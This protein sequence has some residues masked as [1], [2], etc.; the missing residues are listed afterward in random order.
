MDPSV[1][2]ATALNISLASPE[3]GPNL[4]IEGSAAPAD[5]QGRSESAEVG[6]PRGFGPACGGR[7]ASCGV[8]PPRAATEGVPDFRRFRMRD[9]GA[10]PMYAC[11]GHSPVHKE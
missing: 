3:M 10:S 11:W 6:D 9:K 4:H 2:T 1:K 5:R 8:G 7:C